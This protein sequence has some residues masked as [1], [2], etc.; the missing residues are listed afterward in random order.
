MKPSKFRF[1]LAKAETRGDREV[2]PPVWTRAFWRGRERTFALTLTDGWL[3]V[4]DL[5]EPRSWNEPTQWNFVA[6]LRTPQN[7][8]VEVPTSPDAVRAYFHRVMEEGPLMRV[9]CEEAG[10]I[11]GLARDGRG[12]LRSPGHNTTPTPF[13]FSFDGEF[14]D[15][16]LEFWRGELARWQ[17]EES[18]FSWA[19]RWHFAPDHHERRWMLTRLQRGTRG[20]LENIGRRLLRANAVRIAQS[21]LQSHDE[22][23]VSVSV[24]PEFQL[25]WP[26]IWNKEDAPPTPQE[27]ALWRVVADWFAP[28]LDVAQARAHECS[29]VWNNPAFVRIIVSVPCDE[30]TAHELLETRL[31]LRDWLRER[32]GLSDERINELLA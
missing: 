16:P 8:L 25:E 32:I 26:L 22:L 24:V 5:S 27:I 19:L 10:N 31:Q 21:R 14:F 2:A 17:S 23:R 13:R 4:A 1:H 12:E 15:H 6:S 20:E 28:S 18:D 29:R 11:I 7:T 3:R 9:L 30:P